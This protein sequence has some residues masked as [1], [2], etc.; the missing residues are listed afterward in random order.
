MPVREKA[1]ARP[2]PVAL[3][4]RRSSDDHAGATRLLARSRMLIP[5]VVGLMWPQVDA[6]DG[7]IS[8]VADGLDDSLCV[9]EEVRARWLSVDEEAAGSDL[10]VEPFP[11]NVQPPCKGVDAEQV[12]GVTPAR[13]RRPRAQGR[14]MKSASQKSEH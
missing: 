4:G 6:V 9:L 5:C 3:A 13:A 11:R 8:Q 2:F 14:R 1:G 10:A 7:S 12:R